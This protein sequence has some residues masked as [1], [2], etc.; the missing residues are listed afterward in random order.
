MLINGQA[1]DVGALKYI[2][3]N[4]LAGRIVYCAVHPERVHG[5]AHAMHMQT[6]QLAPPSG[7]LL[8]HWP[9]QRAEDS[10]GI[11]VER[12]ANNPIVLLAQRH[13]QTLQVSH[14]IPEERPYA[15]VGLYLRNGTALRIY[16]CKH[17]TECRCDVIHEHS[18]V[19]CCKIHLLWQSTRRQCMGFL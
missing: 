2:L 8:R 7:R 19:H 5:C 14:G 15:D 13:V 1:V 12:A 9:A 16:R 4:N 10:H 18:H 17:L 6:A 3:K 11:T